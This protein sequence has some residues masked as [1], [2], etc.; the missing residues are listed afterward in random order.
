[1][2]AIDRE[3]KTLSRL[4]AETEKRYKDFEQTITEA[5]VAMSKELPFAKDFWLTEHNFIKSSEA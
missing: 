4:E 3:V 1:L 5:E 2:T